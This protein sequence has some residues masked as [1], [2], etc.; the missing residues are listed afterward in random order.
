VP[1]EQH[2]FFSD[3][4]AR[5]IILENCIPSIINRVIGLRTAKEVWDELKRIHARDGL[6]QLDQKNE[7]FASYLPPATTSVIDLSVM[8]IGKDGAKIKALKKLMKRFEME[9]LGPAKYFVGVRITRDREERTIT[10][11]QDAYIN[12]VLEC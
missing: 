1:R 10:L 7:A 2:H 3:N 6:Q 8:F 5:R 12:K 4:R 11:C 9:D